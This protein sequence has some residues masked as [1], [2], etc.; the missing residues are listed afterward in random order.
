MNTPATVTH[1]HHVN[2]ATPHVNGKHPKFPTIEEIQSGEIDLDLLDKLSEISDE[3][4]GTTSRTEGEVG[5]DSS[6][7]PVSSD[8]T[9]DKIETMLL[10]VEGYT[11]PAQGIFLDALKPL[12]GQLPADKRELQGL[13]RIL[14]TG[15][16]VTAF[17]NS[18]PPP[19]GAPTFELLSFDE[20]LAMPPKSWLIDQVIGNGDLGVFYGPPGSGKT[21]AII[22]LMVSACL[23]QQW[24]QRFDATK[25]LNVAY[26][27]GEGLGG[28]PERFRAAGKHYGVTSGLPEFFFSPLVPQLH[29]SQDENTASGID[30]FIRDWQTRNGG[31][32]DL[33]VIDTLHS[34][35]VG[36]DENSSQ[37][38][39]R[40]LSAAKR[41]ISAL[42]CAVL[43][44]HHSNK[45]GTGERGSS[46]LRG[47]SDFM[48]EFK[49]SGT[50]YAMYCEKLKDG[51]EWKSQTFEL[52]AIEGC[53]SVFVA[54]DAPG[55]EDGDGRKTGTGDDILNL[56][57]ENPSESLTAKS[58][59]DALDSTQQAVN[60]VMPRLEK[61]KCVSRGK[62]KRGAWVYTIT[63]TG[64][65][66]IGVVD[67]GL[68]NKQG[69]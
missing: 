48:I 50:K 24:A 39:G 28:L 61:E 43:L 12:I 54:W 3:T 27:A 7:P 44:V 55:G 6:L 53:Q 9:A 26:C 17:L 14:K 21:F 20:L 23:G 29:V 19:P 59:S 46:A 47:A 45:A 57:A 40:V 30:T 67:E 36:A 51:G 63:E 65:L 42:G 52:A 31:E 33:L 60:R 66:H 4:A 38:M 10:L 69:L 5:A 58:I 2:G 32:L 37:D 11:H 64:L 15:K 13:Y 49:K 8:V 1:R 35:S 68:L 18:C 56:L 25:R 16:A 62:N 22:D 34:A 41:A